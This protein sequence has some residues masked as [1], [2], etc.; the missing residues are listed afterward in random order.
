MAST[1]EKLSLDELREMIKFRWQVAS[2]GGQHPFTEE[3]IATIFQYSEGMPREANILADNSLLVA[4]V[5][6]QKQIGKAIV[7]QVVAD[8][9]ENLARKAVA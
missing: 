5:S 9:L 8:R 1:L 6:Q 2:G 4:G 3:A 7:E